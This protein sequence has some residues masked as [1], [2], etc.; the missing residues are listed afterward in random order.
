MSLLDTLI[1]FD[2]P[3]VFRQLFNEGWY[4]DP[5]TKKITCNQA[6][7]INR[8]WVYVNPDQ[9][10][11]C[12]LQQ[13]IFNCCDF[14]PQRCMNCWKVVVKMDYVAQLFAVYDWMK[15]FTKQ[16]FG[17]SRFCKCGME[18]RKHVHYQYGAYFYCD[19]KEQGQK[20]YKEVRAAIDA[21]D[22]S[23]EVTLKRY[24]TEFELRLGPTKSYKRPAHAD[25][26]EEEIAEA[27]EF[28][29]IN[30]TQP[31]YLVR[32]VMR[33]W[34]EHAWDRGDPT[35][36]EFNNGKPFYTPCETYHGE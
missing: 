21:I 31:D 4:I 36:K 7:D 20:R 11:D 29:K 22:P 23:I 34:L 16:S 18:E 24:C 1:A 10:R 9:T 13:A 28:N 17:K 30:P 12:N 19:S 3:T 6:L 14:V 26:C 32:H 2:I 35:A 25:Y 5:K 27:F 33:R 8:P 15:K